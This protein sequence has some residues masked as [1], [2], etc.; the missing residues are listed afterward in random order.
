MAYISQKI[1]FS[2]MQLMVISR[3]NKINQSKSTHKAEN[4]Q[5]CKQTKI[6]QYIPN[7]LPNHQMNIS[8]PRQGKTGLKSIN[9]MHLK[10]S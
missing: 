10:S 5:L 8:P 7:L 9:S 2:H 4:M 3:I 1:D 6:Y